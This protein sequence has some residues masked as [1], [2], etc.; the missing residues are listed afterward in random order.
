V[1]ITPLDTKAIPPATISLVTALD[2][3]T[4]PIG[5]PAASGIMG[6]G[7]A[8]SVVDISS[9][10]QLISIVSSF[11]AA[12]AAT[13]SAG[14]T[15]QTVTASAELLVGTVNQ[16]A[17]NNNNSVESLLANAADAPLQTVFNVP[18]T[19]NP[20]ETLQAALAQVGITAA[21]NATETGQAGQLNLNQASLRAAFSANPSG[22]AAVL[23]QA[24]AALGKFA[25][26]VVRQ[27]AS[28]LALEGDTAPAAVAAGNQAEPSASPTAPSPANAALQSVLNDLALSTAAGESSLNQ[29]PVTQNAASQTAGTPAPAAVSTN[30]AVAN[31]TATKATPQTGATTAGSST[32]AN[33]QAIPA[34]STLT[35]PVSAADPAIAAAVAA[36]RVGESNARNQ[37]NDAEASSGELVTD[38]VEVVRVNPVKFDPHGAA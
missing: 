10:G 25:A 37:E 33:T 20:A 4:L 27:N 3:S 6:I 13:G 15:L 35:Q 38:V 7:G 24:F 9:F 26:T 12:Q 8:A 2:S 5:T 21:S 30:P 28:L 11:Q 34:P 19:S 36:Y 16:F 1:N 17:V 18:S 29:Q 14:N 32:T 31:T 22:T 23:N